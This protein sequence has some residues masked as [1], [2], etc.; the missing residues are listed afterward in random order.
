M[1]IHDRN[2]N[3]D[4]SDSE[5]EAYVQGIYEVLC[6]LGVSDGCGKMYDP[7]TIEGE[8]YHSYVFD[9]WDGGRHHDSTGMSQNEVR[10][11][12]LK[13]AEN[14]IRDYFLSGGK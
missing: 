4:W 6:S 10:K 7:L 3:K 12:F 11:A 8:M 1:S 5:M 14:S 13:E 9:L 2:Y